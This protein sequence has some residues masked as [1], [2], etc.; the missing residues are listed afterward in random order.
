M[1]IF[2]F[3]SLALFFALLSRSGALAIDEGQSRPRLSESV[4]AS[5]NSTINLIPLTS[6]SGNLKGIACIFTAD[7]RFQNQ[8][9]DIFVDGGSAQTLSIDAVFYPAESDGSGRTFT[10][11]IPMN[12]RFETSLKVQLRRPSSPAIDYEVDCSASW[13]VD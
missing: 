1:R 8:L 13:G 6:G 2:R 11:Y 4:I 9:V 10:G 5:H 3:F 12:V 7:A